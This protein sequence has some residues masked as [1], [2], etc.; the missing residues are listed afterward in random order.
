MRRRRVQRQAAVL[1][2][3]R[4]VNL[5]ADLEVG[6]EVGQDLTAQVTAALTAVK[7]REV[8]VSVA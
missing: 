7:R 2:A 4:G 6:Q 5:V 1:V 8:G 3:N